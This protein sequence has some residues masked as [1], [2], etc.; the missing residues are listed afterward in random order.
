[1]TR[2]QDTVQIELSREQQR[3]VFLETGLGFSSLEFSRLGLA[4]LTLAAVASGSEVIPLSNS[5]KTVKFVLGQQ[6]GWI[7][8]SAPRLVAVHLTP[9]QRQQIKQVTGW[10]ISVVKLAPDEWKVSYKEK[11]ET[12]AVTLHLGQSLLIVSQGKLSDRRHYEKVIELP[13][14]SQGTISI[15]GTGKHE[16][17][18]LCLRLLEK[19][20]K[21]GHRLLD[22][23]TGSG[24][25]AIAAAR[26]GAG[27]VD[28]LDI[29]P[30]A[31]ALAQKSVM[32]N[33]VM[34]VVEV[35]VGSIE[36]AKPLY[37]IVVANIFTASL[38]DMAN[39]LAKAMMP[40]G[41]LIVSGIVASRVGEVSQVI[42]SAGFAF[43]E[44]E[45]QGDWSGLTFQKVNCG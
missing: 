12:D 38:I 6:G 45:S 31:A 1:V 4:A 25:L 2:L 37:D 39:D 17:T 35:N 16:T 28:A 3:Q 5:P 22:L 9:T 21:P 24:I 33:S 30:E 19:F 44:M 23:G 10:N 27:H 7:E 8:S 32:I 43:V 29:N 42:C 34:D 13:D 36:S 20:V 11:W 41:L 15:F 40:S 26:L 18:Q 14:A